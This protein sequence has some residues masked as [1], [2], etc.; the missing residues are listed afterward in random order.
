MILPWRWG[1]HRGQSDN[2]SLASQDAA[3]YQPGDLVNF[4]GDTVVPADE[5]AAYRYPLASSSIFAKAS[6]ADDSILGLM[7]SSYEAPTWGG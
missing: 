2:D 6:Y 4:S 3:R 1:G 7:H 5:R